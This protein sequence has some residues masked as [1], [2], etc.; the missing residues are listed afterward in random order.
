MFV[1]EDFEEPSEFEENVS[2]ST[3]SS[4]IDVLQQQS[5][6]EHIMFDYPTYPLEQE[7][8]EAEETILQASKPHLEKNMSVS[9][10][11]QCICGSSSPGLSTMVECHSCHALF[12]GDCVGISRQKALLLK[13][14]YCMV[15]MDK[16]SSL[17]NEFETKGTMV[18]ERGGGEEFKARGHEGDDN[19]GGAAQR[20]GRKRTVYKSKKG[21]RT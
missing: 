15:C 8:Q 13:H 2:R 6:D 7:T 11:R 9:P 19:G 5:S 14:F 12:H 10:L 4:P 3:T 20:G 18:T 21:N 17:V 16:D 1:C